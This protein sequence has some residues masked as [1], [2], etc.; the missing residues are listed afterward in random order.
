M[1]A[2]VVVSSLIVS[3]GLAGGVLTA[4]K[5]PTEKAESR[6]MSSLKDF[7]SELSKMNPQID[8]V[9]NALQ[10]TV[11]GD[12]PNPSASFRDFKDQF[13]TMQKH[14]KR[15]AREADDATSGAENYFQKFSKEIQEERNADEQARARD[16]A[17]SQRMNYD[18]FA[19]TLRNGKRN[20]MDLVASLS[21]IQAKLE[22]GINAQSISAINPSYSRATD[23]AIS[24]KGA[25]NSMIDAINKAVA[26]R[27]K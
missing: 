13:G 3:L 2:K 8:K 18:A 7:R 6:A 16:T 14:A 4:C 12:N 1:H 19:E 15:V 9:M 17:A 10:K 22:G 27:A 23:N 21:D 26:G 20:Y 11:A 5:T 24:T 25:V